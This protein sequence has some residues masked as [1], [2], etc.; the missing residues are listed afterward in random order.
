MRCGTIRRTLC[1]NKR[2]NCSRH[3]AQKAQC[4]RPR[5]AKAPSRR[6]GHGR[7]PC[8]AKGARASEDEAT[9]ACRKGGMYPT[10]DS[11]A[12]SGEIPVFFGILPYLILKVTWFDS[13]SGYIGAREGRADRSREN[14]NQTIK[15]RTEIKQSKSHKYHFPIPLVFSIKTIKTPGKS[16]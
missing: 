8:L 13:A 6:T 4:A 1:A 15:C 14:R 9:V 12:G 7:R 16:R 10:F 2:P 3:V 5:C 11:A